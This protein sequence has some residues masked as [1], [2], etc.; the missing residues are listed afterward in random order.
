M[1]RLTDQ[2]YWEAYYSNSITQRKQIESVA[3]V[4]DTYWDM[5]V[6]NNTTGTSPK[7]IIEI[8]GYP[9]R[10]LAYL[11]SK[12]NLVPTSLDFNSDIVKIQESMAAF[13]ITEYDIVQADIFKH[14]PTQKYDIVI[15]NGFIEHFDNFNEVLDKHCLYLKDNG[16]LLI[17]IP[18]KRGLRKWYGLALDYKNLK[19]HNL[20]CMSKKTF[21]DFAKR[22][23]LQTLELTYFGGF[24]FS[25][26]QKSNF[27][28]KSIYKVARLFFKKANPFLAKH[29]SRF[30]SST[31]MSVYKK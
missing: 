14:Q 23:N 18:N 26:H 29:P 27:I 1:E 3:S 5:I 24:P 28:Q 12:Y 13:G 7:T 19:A 21:S 20:K 6:D 22:N 25:L 31:I 16:T 11:A 10:Y 15:S 30:Y 8:G 17:M 9:G 4:Y 2:A